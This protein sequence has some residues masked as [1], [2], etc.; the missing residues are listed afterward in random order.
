MANLPHESRHRSGLDRFLHCANC[1]WSS[2]VRLRCPAPPPPA[3]RTL[4]CHGASDSGL[5]SGAVCSENVPRLP[6]V[7]ESGSFLDRDVKPERLKLLDVPT[8]SFLGVAPIEVVG[9]KLLVG[10]AVA[11]DVEGNLEDL[12]PNGHDRLLV[13]PVPRDPVISGLQGRAVLAHGPQPCLNHRAALVPIAFAGFAASA[14]SRTFVL[15]RT[16]GAPATQLARRE[17]P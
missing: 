10:D 13:P 11:H 16:N 8:D 7:C 1:H 14:L 9:P 17:K 6:P 15:S 3:D 4:Q 5:D 12:M 2:P